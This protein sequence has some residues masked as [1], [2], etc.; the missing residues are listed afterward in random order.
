MKYCI[1]K[2]PMGSF[3]KQQSPGKYID[4]TLYA[5][6]EILAKKIVDDMTFLGVGFS[7]TLEVGTGKSVFMQTIGE[8]Y[9]EL[10]NKK[11]GLD[12]PF[13]EKN[14]VFRPK[15]LIDTAFSLPKYSC[16]ILDEWEDAHYW[17][18]LGMTLRQFFRKC[19]QLNLFILV[20]IPNFFQLNTG[21]AISRSV[22]AVDVKFVGEFQRG[23]F[24][25]YNFD[26]KRL[27]YLKG[28]KTYDYNTAKANFSGSFTD[29]YAVGEE[30]YRKKK[31]NDLTKFEE[32]E[33]KPPTEKEIKQKIF[34]EINSL[35]PEVAQK[36]LAEAFVVSE[37]TAQ[38]WVSKDKE[39]RGVFSNEAT[40]KPPEIINNLIVKDNGG[41]VEGIDDINVDEEPNNQPNAL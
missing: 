26:R 2:Y 33:V 21:Y 10:V 13:T 9:T 27:L 15:D 12:I 22:F 29:G 6:L 34:C 18:E 14:I 17:S 11:H 19:R 36:R 1:E 25:F 16:I 24:D 41:V 30:A 31:L 23:F 38:R 35:L 5:N 4:G 39:N 7:S 40:D 37:R 28:K 8:C 20:I 3:K 32:G